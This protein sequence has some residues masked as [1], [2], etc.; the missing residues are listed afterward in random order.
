MNA[1]PKN[2]A[3]AKII[4]IALRPGIATGST[5]KFTSRCVSCPIATKVYLPGGN[6]PIKARLSPQKPGGSTPGQY[7]KLQSTVTTD[8][9]ISIAGSEGQ[10][11]TLVQFAVT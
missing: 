1:E 11:S 10:A 9:E 5:S 7:P 8:P 6:R 3:T 2:S 4:P